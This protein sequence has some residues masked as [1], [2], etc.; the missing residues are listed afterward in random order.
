M[1]TYFE[2]RAGDLV[3][4]GRYG[5][6]LSL[7]GLRY[8]I[9]ATFRLWATGLPD[10]RGMI[11]GFTTPYQPFFPLLIRNDHTIHVVSEEQ[12]DKTRKETGHTHEGGEALV[13]QF[14]GFINPKYI[15]DLL[16]KA[17]QGVVYETQNPNR[18]DPTRQRV[19]RTEKIQCGCGG[20][21]TYPNRQKHFATARH[22]DYE[23][24]QS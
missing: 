2:V 13:N 3:W 1:T 21:Y 14:V 23:A 5:E 9:Y 8:L 22:R 6:T 20:S 17:Q 4:A 24:I 16:H 18:R 7:H 10:P 19:D 12:Y 15:N 11:K